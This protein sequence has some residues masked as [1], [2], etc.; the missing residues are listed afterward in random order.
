MLD[1]LEAMELV[2]RSRSASDRRIVTCSLTDHGR[3]LITEKR[4]RWEGY[5][6]K[7]LTEFSAEEIARTAAVLDRMREM[8]DEIDAEAAAPRGAASAS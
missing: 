1:A 8:Y 2:R 7:R 6:R 4:A 3:E 5:F